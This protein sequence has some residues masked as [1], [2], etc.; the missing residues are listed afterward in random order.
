MMPS[1]RMPAYVLQQQ[2]QGINRKLDATMPAGET[3]ADMVP[4]ADNNPMDVGTVRK[5]L[6][7]YEYR[8]ALDFCFK[9]KQQSQATSHCWR[10]T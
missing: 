4:R 1:S 2:Q 6:D 7:N 3:T 8:T 5:K 10:R 9:Y